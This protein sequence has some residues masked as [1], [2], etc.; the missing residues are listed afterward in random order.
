MAINKVFL[1]GNL[2]ADPELRYTTGQNAVCQL[3]IATTEKRKG[4]DG[5]WS[6]HTEWHQ[7]VV[8]GKQAENCKQYL[9]KGR[10]AFIEGRLQTRKWQDKEGNNRYSTEIVASNVQFVGGR[11]E[12]SSQGSYQG[13]NSMPDFGGDTMDDP[14]ASVK[15]AESI[16]LDD[17][18]IPF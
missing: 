5:N 18:D 15:P 8:W 1:L 6:D 7:V 16:S 3:R 11:G 14:F 9:A 4:A 13:N 10:Q 17:D 12:S 2:G